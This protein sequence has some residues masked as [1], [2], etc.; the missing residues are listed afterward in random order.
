MGERLNKILPR[1][2]S[3][4][5][6]SGSGIG[7]EI[8]FYIFDYPP[9]D[10]LRVRDFLRT[11]LHHIPMQRH[12]M[13][14]KHIDL[15]DFMLEHLRGRNLLDKAIELQRT[16]GDQ[17]LKKALSGPLHESKLS[18]PFAEAAQ[19]E[20]HDLIIASGAGLVWPLLRTHSLLNNLQPVMGNT[21]L[22]LFYPGRYDGQSLR[23]FGKL[24]NNNY[25]RAFKLVP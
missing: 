5:F 8:A 12:G 18:A 20:Q 13:R 24:K 19:P 6:L 23:L 7:N 21:P 11:L 22:L 14:V 15:F 1:I 17:A 16:K 4:E 2:I 9:E 25:Y 3:D 10:E